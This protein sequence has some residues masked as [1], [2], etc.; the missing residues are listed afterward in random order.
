MCEQN[1]QCGKC[2]GLNRPMVEPELTEGFRLRLRKTLF[3]FVG[4]PIS[5]ETNKSLKDAVME[6]DLNDFRLSEEFYC[7]CRIGGSNEEGI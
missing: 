1:I 2:G 7:T 6:I 5:K 4:Q 3:P